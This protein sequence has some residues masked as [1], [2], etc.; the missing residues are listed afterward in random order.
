MLCPYCCDREADSRDHVFPDFLGGR[1][2]ISACSRCN[3]TFGHTIEAA[4]FSHLRNLMFFLRHSGMQP[5]K[6]M[7]WR[8]VGIGA[9]GQRYDIDQDLKATPSTPTI[10]R[11]MTGRI[12]RARGSK[13][14][15]DQIQR[16]LA[17]AGRSAQIVAEPVEFDLRRLNMTFPM[18]GA[19]KRLC[20]KMS[21]AAPQMRGA[22]AALDFGTRRYLLEGIQ[23]D[24]CPV[25]I[26]INE[27]VELDRQRPPVGHLLYVRAASSEGRTY[28]I[29]QLF[30]AIQFYCE[31][32]RD[33]SGPDW[34]LLA[35]HS[36]VDHSER[37]EFVAPVDFPLPERHVS[38]TLAEHFQKGLERMRLELV[39]LYGDQAPQNLSS[40]H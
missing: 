4:A 31:L 11:D 12:T 23:L 30:A 35:T 8:G 16:S 26:A 7:V 38:G 3:S 25:R 10:E 13:R 37:I 40:N 21:I 20:L 33:Y 1:A 17:R 5:P 32:A 19:I 24:V 14:H 15:V 29:V 39:A 28:S 36:P 22:S 2:W 6:P 9:S 27:Y 34:A 18:D